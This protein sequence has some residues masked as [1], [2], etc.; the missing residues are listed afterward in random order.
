MGFYFN[1]QC[2]VD[3]GPALG[4]LTDVLPVRNKKEM[5]LTKN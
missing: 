1:I 4:K 2:E 3:M 5:K